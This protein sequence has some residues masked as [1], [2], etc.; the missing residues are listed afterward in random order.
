MT[1]YA[2]V[3]DVQKFRR[4]T[5]TDGAV[6]GALT[7]HLED[8]T[9]E[10]TREIGWSYFRSPETGTTTRILHGN[11]TNRLHVHEGIAELALVEVRYSTTEDWVE[12]AA[13]DWYLEAA[14]GEPNALDGEP[15][16]HVVLDPSGNY[17]TFP[18][19]PL[20]VRLTLATGWPAVPTYAVA[21]NVAWARQRLALDPAMAGQVGPEDMGVPTG[22]D[23]WP[24]AVYDL[25]QR[26]KQRHWCSM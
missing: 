15:Y 17:R 24:R 9:V 7:Q 10:L 5:T 3:A 11:G 21:A 6:V 13:T 23:R 22:P 1:S 14:P 18:S 25:V 12:L 16:F 19:G 2:S 20:R 4:V 26:E 8:T